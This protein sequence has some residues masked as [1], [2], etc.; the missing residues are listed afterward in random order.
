MKITVVALFLLQYGVSLAMASGYCDVLCQMEQNVKEVSASSNA[1]R[2][3]QLFVAL[4]EIA[5]KDVARSQQE[6]GSEGKSAD[7]RSDTYAIEMKGRSLQLMGKIGTEECIQYLSNIKKNSLTE[8]ERRFVWAS[9]QLG[10][11]MARASMIRDK[12]ERVHFLEELLTQNG[13]EAVVGDVKYWAWQWLCDHGSTGSFGIISAAV[14]EYYADRR[15][16]A[17]IAYCNERMRYISSSPSRLAALE[18]ALLDV[19]QTDERLRQWAVTS[20][21][22]LESADA[23]RILARFIDWATKLP[24]GSKEQSEMYPLVHGIRVNRPELR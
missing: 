11:S 13:P 16:D 24:M 1:E 8:R 10:L 18:T 20:L 7:L 3:H 12:Y 19:G 14:Q 22:E 5:E 2:Q 9:A 21:L 23:D 4:R 17:E 6:S 15:A